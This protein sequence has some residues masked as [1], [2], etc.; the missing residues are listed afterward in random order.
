MGGYT[1]LLGD[2]VPLADAVLALGVEDDDLPVAKAK[3]PQHIGLLQRRLAVAGLAEDE[4]VRGGQLLAVELE[5]VV[6]V[7]LAGVH[8]TPDDHARVAEAGCRGRQVDG[9]RL[10]G[11]G[12][13][14]QPGGLDLSEEEAG[15]GVGDGGK[16]IE[17]GKTPNVPTSLRL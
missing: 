6:D 8:L 7:A 11:G 2:Q 1:Q 4:P 3:L 16:R 10:S 5:G 14:G 12:P 17:H 9:L 15:E 13:Y